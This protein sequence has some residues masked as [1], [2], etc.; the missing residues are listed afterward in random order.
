MKTISKYLAMLLVGLVLGAIIPAS[1]AHYPCSAPAPIEN[2]HP[3]P[4]CGYQTI[5]D[6][7]GNVMTV[8]VCD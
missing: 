6:A 2:A 3:Q 8:Y 4:V 1:V 7:F 5:V